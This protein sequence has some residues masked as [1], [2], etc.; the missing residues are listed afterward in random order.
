MN[1]VWFPW[2]RVIRTAVQVFVSITTVLALTAVLAPQVIT[3]LA[4]VL[5]V[6]VVAWL[7]AAVASVTA[8]SMALS[9]LMLIPLVN[10]FLTRFGAGTAPA[11]AVAVTLTDGD[12]IPMTRVEYRTHLQALV[13]DADQA[14]A[15]R[16]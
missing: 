8:L 5:P 13:D 15:D 1:K 6:P 9:R 3:A 14:N 11:G 7:T 2:Q 4:D 10:D 16:E 12:H